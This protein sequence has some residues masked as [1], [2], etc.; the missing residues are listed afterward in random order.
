MGMGFD[1]TGIK[2]LSQ[3][4]L[5]TVLVKESIWW[6]IHKPDYENEVV[7]SGGLVVTTT[8]MG[9]YTISY[10][11]DGFFFC[12]FRGVNCSNCL[13]VHSSMFGWLAKHS[14]SSSIVL[15]SPS[16]ARWPIL[17]F[18]HNYFIRF[19]PLTEINCQTL[20]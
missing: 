20:T 11:R 9:I 18:A 10:W 13:S 3:M 2:G 15:C 17:Y 5:M 14:D 1:K 16:I 8:V 4:D 7:P 19:T 12:S 6:D